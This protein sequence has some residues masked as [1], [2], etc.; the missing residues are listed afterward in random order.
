MNTPIPLLLF[1]AD[2]NE[3]LM[4]KRF[5]IQYIFHCGLKH[6][7]I[8]SMHLYSLKDF[9]QYQEHGKR[10]FGL[11]IF[12]ITNKTNNQLSFIVKLV[13]VLIQ[14]KVYSNYLTYSTPPH[15]KCV[16]C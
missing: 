7:A 15:V 16:K 9:Q 14:I 5:N 4:K 10:H 13:Q 6:Y 2:L 3:F 11:G 12:N 8:N 1:F